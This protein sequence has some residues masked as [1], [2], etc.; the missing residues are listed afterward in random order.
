MTEW[1]D[2][3]FRIYVLV[4]AG[5]GHTEWIYVSHSKDDLIAKID[6]QY[7]EE[8]KLFDEEEDKNWLRGFWYA[9]REMVIQHNNWEPGKYVLD[10]IEPVWEEWTLHIT[11]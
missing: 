4:Q 10:R 2:K 1:M 7:S 5:E 6:K 11:E 8:V 9:L 3:N